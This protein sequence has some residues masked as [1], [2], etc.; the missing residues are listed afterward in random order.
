MKPPIS[1]KVTRSNKK[2]GKANRKE[3]AVLSDDDDESS[4]EEDANMYSPRREGDVENESDANLDEDLLGDDDEDLDTGGAGGMDG[5]EV[6][7]DRNCDTASELT[8]CFTEAHARRILKMDAVKNES[9]ILKFVVHEV[10]KDLKFTE[11]DEDQE[12]ELCRIAFDDGYVTVP[13][14]RILE[15]AFISE[16]YST[17]RVLQKT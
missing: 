17:I 12:M 2:S 7:V 6:V 9:M 4:E 10:F 1:K 11:G 16:Y 8:A 13:D 14:Q 5:R 15:S 3:D